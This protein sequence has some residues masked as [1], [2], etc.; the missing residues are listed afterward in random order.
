MVMVSQRRAVRLTRVDVSSASAAK[1]LNV[2][3]GGS[4][5]KT[6]CKTKETR[7]PMQSLSTRVQI[8]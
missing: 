8:F 4:E 2:A 1:A 6:N 5:E 7:G 3:P